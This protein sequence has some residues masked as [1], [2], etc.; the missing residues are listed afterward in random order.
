MFRLRTAPLKI[1]PLRSSHTWCL[2]NL[3]TCETV[4][5]GLTLTKIPWRFR[6][7]RRIFIS[8]TGPLLRPKVFRPVK[9]HAFCVRLTHFGPKLPLTPARVAESRCLTHFTKPGISQNL[10]DPQESMT[11][12]IALG[13]DGEAI[14]GL[15]F[16]DLHK[17][18]MPRIFFLKLW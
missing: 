10:L 14:S 5:R 6:I 2:M 12:Q 11:Y 1:S 13:F 4:F 16:S 9:S 18:D 7:F 3:L 17:A 8:V 15:H